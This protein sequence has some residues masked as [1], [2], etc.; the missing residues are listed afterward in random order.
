MGA[1]AGDLSGEVAAGGGVFAAAV[2]EGGVPSS[3]GD[4]SFFDDGKASGSESA[5]AGFPEAAEVTKRTRELLILL[6][7]RYGCGGVAEFGLS[8]VFDLSTLP[9]SG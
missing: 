1:G 4:G 8:G 9:S 2:S 6:G 7:Q 3:A 5:D